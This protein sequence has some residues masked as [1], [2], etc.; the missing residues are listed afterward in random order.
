M[1]SKKTINGEA[2][3]IGHEQEEESKSLFCWA[4]DDG[5]M[6]DYEE[7]EDDL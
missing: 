5:D 1:L 2:D 7:D 6:V 4:E 3:A